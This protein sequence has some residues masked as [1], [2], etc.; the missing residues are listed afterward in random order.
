MKKSGLPVQ[1]ALVLLFCG[2]GAL[3]IYLPR[4]LL[5]SSGKLEFGSIRLT[6]KGIMQA[7]ATIKDPEIDF[8]IVELG[9]IRRVEIEND[10]VII[11]M[12]FT[13]PFCPLA[14]LIVSLIEEK[15]GSI[16]GVRE[17]GVV[18]DETVQWDWSM[19]TEEGKKKLQAYLK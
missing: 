4:L 8:T 17:V 9:L 11:T 18:I 19:M 12:I 1:I 10:K 2:L 6:N 15:I 16:K 3:L 14:D 7:L 13:S 5:S